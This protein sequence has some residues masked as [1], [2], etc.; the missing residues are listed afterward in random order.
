[1]DKRFDPST[2]EAEWQ[3]R[4]AERGWFTADAASE[5]APFCIMI[6]PPNVTG[7]LHMGHALQTA[8]QDLL[9]RWR[10]MQG[11]N[12]LWV[13][14]TDHAGIA[15]Q[16]MVERQLEQEGTSRE[17]IGR[18]AFLERVWAW[19]EDHHGDI[20]RQLD[21]LGASC[22]WT[23]ERFT[24]D[25]GLSAAVRHA[26]VELYRRGKIKRDEYMVNWSPGL[27]TAVSDLEVEMREVEGSLYRIAYPVVGSDLSIVVATTRPETMLGDTAVAYHPDDERYAWLEGR[28]ARLPILGREIPFVADAAVERDFGTGLVKVT[29]FH[30]PADF[31]LGR[32]HDLP[33]IQVIGEDARMTEA[34]GPDFA[35]LDRF[36]ARRAVVD[37]LRAEG[38]LESVERWVH[39]VGHC[40]R[41]GVPIEPLISLQWFLDVSSMAERALAANRD[42]AL[43]LVPASWDKTWTHWLESIR[44]WCISRQLWWGHRIP[45]WYDEAG[46]CWVAESVEQAAREA[47]VDPARLVEDPDVLDTW[48]SS[49]L[50]PLSTLGWPEATEDLETFYPTSVLVTGYDILFFWVA[51]MVMFGLEFADQVPFAE[52]HLTGLVRDAEGQKMSKTKGNTVDPLELV[53]EY[54]A[55]ALRFTLAALDSPGRDIP[56]DP[57]RMA[58]YRAFGN[59]IWN[60]TRFV[61][62]RIDPG[63]V[64]RP[65]DESRLEAPELWIRSRLAQAAA[66]VNER[67][68]TFRFD[69]ACHRLY[70]FFWGDLCDWYLELSKPALSGEAERPFVREVLIEVLEESL[71][72]LHPVMPFLTEELWQRLPGVTGR[73]GE[74]IV[75]AP[76]PTGSEA[77]HNPELERHVG[78]FFDVVGGVRKLRAE[79]GVA[80]RERLILHLAADDA[81]LGGW[82]AGQPRLLEFLGGLDSVVEGEPPPVA[83][84]DRVGGVLI[85]V[86]LAG[87]ETGG[88]TGR[89]LGG[90]QRRRLENE[91]AELEGLI[92]RARRQLANPQ[93]VERAPAEVVEGKRDSL[94]E[95]EERLAA[96]RTG[97]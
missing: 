24:L 87:G 80:P 7:R 91:V 62:G 54:G 59:K 97:L 26:F 49:G 9:V 28:V 20:R 53:E 83:A 4:W 19:K 84:R 52:V 43:K 46:N 33:A 42:G 13:P 63:F 1:M 37:R 11:R 32:R 38:R 68:E 65:I 29:P 66:E 34:A 88:E 14:G 35:G 5:R 56:L 30:D 89:D 15:T 94:R 55:D 57:E 77:R 6:P 76:Y 78:A 3:R 22:D 79:L 85:G 73:H 2:Y 70:H 47:G 72:L 86:S 25:E 12:A 48:F 36:E 44:P 96:V 81:E 23:R 31:E 10:R 45:A 74:T 41:S 71:R 16:L 93:F 67:F 64:A 61:L 69:A 18:E 8:I 75:L 58:G 50:W 27:G 40:Q 60:A 90:E 17:A 95:L 51:R 82:L 92:E 21:L 39:N